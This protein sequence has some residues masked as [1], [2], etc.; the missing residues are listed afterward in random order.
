ML[1]EFGTDFPVRLAISNVQKSIKYVEQDVMVDS[2][3]DCW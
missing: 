1:W 2:I 3:K